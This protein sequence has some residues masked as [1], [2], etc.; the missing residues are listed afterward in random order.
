M[1]KVVADR[2][3]LL[4]TENAFNVLEKAIDYIDKFI[5]RNKLYSYA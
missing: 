2:M 4:S 1:K 3:S 5:R